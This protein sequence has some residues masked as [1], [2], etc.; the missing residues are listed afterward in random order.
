MCS[1]PLYIA[2]LVC[3]SFCYLERI[4]KTWCSL[5]YTALVCPC[6]LE[7][8]VCVEK[9]MKPL[10]GAKLPPGSS[11]LTPAQFLLL[12]LNRIRPRFHTNCLLVFQ[13][14]QSEEQIPSLQKAK[15][16]VIA[17]KREISWYM[18]KQ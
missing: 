5:L 11:S 10:T 14:F 13:I 4:R 8:V 15:K 1:L 17:A 7:C 12:V 3:L 16:L 9:S 18:L 2:I 6:S